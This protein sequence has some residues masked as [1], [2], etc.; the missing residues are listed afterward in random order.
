MSKQTKTHTIR[1]SLLAVVAVGASGASALAE[2]ETA[3]T[4]LESRALVLKHL[5][6]AGSA[7]D[8]GRFTVS[9]T[10][11]GTI[12]I[13]ANNVGVGTAGVTLVGGATAGSVS[14]SGTG[15][16]NVSLTITPTT[17]TG[18]GSPML[19]TNVG[20]S[21]GSNALGASLSTQLDGSGNGGYSI[22]GTLNV[23]ANQTPGVY[24][25]TVDVVVTYV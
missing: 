14:F 4:T 12:A 21:D 13:G 23:A 24:T 7:I 2:G 15:N 10:V 18:P 1:M 6:I 3:S 20:F 19:L 22:Y 25:G 8:F 11:P 17:L 5:Q 16:Q 9:N